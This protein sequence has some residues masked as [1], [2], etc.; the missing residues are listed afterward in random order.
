MTASSP[1]GLRTSATGAE[2][3]PGMAPSGAVG[4]ERSVARL[5]QFGTYLSIGLL[6]IGAL[7][8]I[9]NGIGPRSG[10]PAFDLGRLVGDLGAGR[11][12]GFLWLGLLVVIATPAARVAVSGVGYVRRGER[13]MAVVAGL[14]LIVIATSVL[15]ARGLQG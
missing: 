2:P 5:L 1:G 6:L 11:P 4:L 15:L 13:E 9:A 3:E 7:L 8:M 10:G 12:A 14:I